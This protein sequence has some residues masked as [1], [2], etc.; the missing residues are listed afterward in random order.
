M[1]G[2]PIPRYERRTSYREIP[3]TGV[4]AR[5]PPCGFA[6]VGIGMALVNHDFTTI[7]V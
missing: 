2:R 1:A 4:V 6:T 7:Q 3:H 5:Q